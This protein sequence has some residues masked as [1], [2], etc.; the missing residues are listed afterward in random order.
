MF[1]IYPLRATNPSDLPKTADWEEHHRNVKI[2]LNLLKN[3]ATVW[4][5]WGDPILQ[6]PWLLG[7]LMDIQREI[8]NCKN[9]INWVKMGNLTALG[10][11]RHPSRLRQQDFSV[12]KLG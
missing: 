12:F 4:A 7:C 8:Q 3:G 9:G 10:N 1:N 2:I 5:A 11:P 6:K